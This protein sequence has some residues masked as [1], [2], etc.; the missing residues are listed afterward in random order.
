MPRRKLSQKASARWARKQKK[1][2]NCTNCG[3]PRNK[4]K[5]LCDFHQGQTTAYMRRYRQHKKETA[6]AEVTVSA[7]NI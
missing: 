5:H 6:P 2:G 7:S 1:M 3:K 4:Y